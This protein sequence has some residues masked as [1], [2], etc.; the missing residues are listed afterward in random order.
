MTDRV[1][2]RADVKGEFLD[3]VRILRT[4]VFLLRVAVRVTNET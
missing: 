4:V 2:Y 1:E 3:F